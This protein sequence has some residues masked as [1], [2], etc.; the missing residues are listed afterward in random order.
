[1]W[2]S[3]RFP[4]QVVFISVPVFF[5][6]LCPTGVS[7]LWRTRVSVHISHCVQS[8]YELPLL[9][10]NTALKPF[11]CFD[12]IFVIPAPDWPW[13]GEYVT[14]DSKFCWFIFKQEIM[15]APSY[16]RPGW[17]KSRAIH[18]H[19]GHRGMLQDELLPTNAGDWV[20]L[21]ADLDG[22]DKQKPCFP[23][24]HSNLRPSSA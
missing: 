22:R 23:C 16:W 24:R 3:G 19:L 5:Y 20:R 13:L 8:V 2:H 10:S 11:S 12:W 14:S 4:W 7:M 1:M 9:P 6:F 21:R 18:P 15:T 17:R